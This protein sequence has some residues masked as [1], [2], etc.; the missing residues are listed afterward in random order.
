MFRV[1]EINELKITV[2][3]T[4]RIMNRQIKVQESSCVNRQPILRE[5]LDLWQTVLEQLS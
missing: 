1:V 3:R 2:R 5:V 4:C